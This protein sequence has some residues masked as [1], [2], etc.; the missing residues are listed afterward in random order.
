METIASNQSQGITS[1][2][3]EYVTLQKELIKVQTSDKAAQLATGVSILVFFSTFLLVGVMAMTIGLGL[4]INSL[5][6]STYAGFFVAGS[7]VILLG[8]L[9]YVLGKERLENFISFKILKIFNS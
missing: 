1:K 2:I 5:L 4:F 9:L 6:E 8:I 7:I 3:K